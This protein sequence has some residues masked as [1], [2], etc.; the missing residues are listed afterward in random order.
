M[1]CAANP[2]EVKGRSWGKG[3]AVPSGHHTDFGEIG[4]KASPELQGI[5][6]GFLEKYGS[7]LLEFRDFY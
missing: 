7:L 3:R 2:G 5:I 6:W 1:Q 4:C